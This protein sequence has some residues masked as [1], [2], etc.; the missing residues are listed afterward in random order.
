MTAQ[1]MA[2]HAE[3]HNS[4]QFYSLRPG[5]SLRQAI[6]VFLRGKN[7]ASVFLREHMA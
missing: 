1:E 3:R 2:G 6:E 4:W 7:R 5:S